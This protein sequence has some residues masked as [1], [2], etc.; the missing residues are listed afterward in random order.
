MRTPTTVAGMTRGYVR[1]FPGTL[2]K[3]RIVDRYLNPALR[4]RPVA[5]STT[6]RGG[7][8]MALDTKDIV[9]RYLY[10]FGVWEPSLTAWLTRVLRPGDVFVDVG[11]NVGYF[12]LL[13]APIVGHTGSVVAIECSPAAYGELLRNLAVNQIGNVRPVRAAVAAA[14]RELAFYEPKKGIHSVTTSV[15]ESDDLEPAFT[16]PAKPLPALLRPAEL[17]A[18]RVVKIDIEGGE[19]AAL[20]GL[21]PALDGARPDVEIVVEVNETMLAR[22]QRTIAETTALLTDRG[23]HPYRLVNSYRP[24]TYLRPPSAPRR[25]RGPITGQ[26]D[27]IF[28]RHDGETL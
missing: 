19:Y 25:V 28:S 26:A 7:A 15:P 8:R 9:Q 3:A 5:R 13:A 23:F 14:E 2:G 24:S 10:Q 1:F 27:L 18:A 6:L 11:A 21:A 12:S 4:E 17:A 16:A 22:Q 20:S